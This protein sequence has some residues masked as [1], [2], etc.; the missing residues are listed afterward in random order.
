MIFYSERIIVASFASNIHRLQQIISAAYKC[1][2]KVAVTGRSMVN[3]VTI[4]SELGYFAYSKGTL[5][6]IE[7]IV[8]LPKEQVVIITTGSQGEPMSAL[9]R[10]AMSDHKR[11]E[12][13]PGDISYNL[14]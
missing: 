2:R 10:M 12:I 9:A 14:C 7:D 13:I 6:E 4:A 8:N 1:G 11:L 3:N 5:V